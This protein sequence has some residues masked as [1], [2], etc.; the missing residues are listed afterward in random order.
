MLNSATGE[1]GGALNIFGF[2]APGGPISITNCS[3]HENEATS[4]SGGFGGAIYISLGRADLITSTFTNNKGTGGGALALGTESSTVVSYSTFDQNTALSSGGGIHNRNSLV[5]R[6]STFKQ[7]HANQES[8]GAI[9]NFS[10]D[11]G[12]GQAF[13][14]IS[15]STLSGNTATLFGGAISNY[16]SHLQISSS[17][18]VGNSAQFGS[19]IS[20]HSI[21]TARQV[22][23]AN[24]VFANDGVADNCYVIA[25]QTNIVS[26]G[27]DYSTDSTCATTAS[28]RNIDPLLGPLA[29]NGGFTLTHIPLPGSP[30][31]DNATGAQCLNLDQRGVSRPQGSACDVGSVEVIPAS[32]TPTPT[33]TATPLPS[34][35]LSARDLVNEA[36]GLVKTA[37][38]FLPAK[39]SASFTKSKRAKINTRRKSILRSRKTLKFDIGQLQSLE[40]TSGTEIRTFISAFS[41]ET[42]NKLKTNVSQAISNNESHPAD[43]KKFWKQVTKTLALLAAS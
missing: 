27:F 12:V 7:N 18:L 26:S 32:P 16:N 3:F 36:S 1:G 8:G 20:H 42:L 34:A 6:N 43:A 10:A 41:G 22:D 19:G 29:D 28:R 25:S 9:L 21:F 2:F 38:K 15:N 17:T 35:L 33:A 40:S 23:L 14:L 24:S 30:L 13:S 11:S 39:P 4:P 37:R 5:V 31:L